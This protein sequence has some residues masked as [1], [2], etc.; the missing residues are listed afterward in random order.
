MNDQEDLRYYLSEYIDGDMNVNI[1]SNDVIYLIELSDSTN[2]VAADYQD[3]VLYVHRNEGAGLIGAGHLF[4]VLFYVTNSAA[5]G[6]KCT[7]VFMS[8]S[9]KDQN[10]SELGVDAADVG[11]FMVGAAF[12]LGDVNGD[13]VV[14]VDGDYLLAMQMAV[15]SVLPN[16]DQLKAGDIDGD[17]EITKTDATLIKRLAQG[18]PINPQSGGGGG[19]GGPAGQTNGYEISIGDYEVVIG[20]DI[21]VPLLLDN[22]EGVAD[23]QVRVN[24]DKEILS[25]LS[26]TNGT[27]TST[28]GVA[29]Q[30][31]A[32]YVDIVLSSDQALVGGNGE[33]AV[34]TFRVDW[35][36][37][38][39]SVSELTISE[40]GL[41][42]QYGEDLSWSSGL[43]SE[44]GVVWAVLSNGLDSDGDG[45]TDYQ[46]HTLDGRLS[47][48][49]W[50]LSN[51]YGTDTDVNDA[52]T[53]DDRMNDGDEKVAGTSALDDG[54]YLGIS[55]MVPDIGSSGLRV[56]W[57]SVDGIEYSVE[58][59]LDLSGSF[60]CIESNVAGTAPEN[61]YLDA[62]AID[63][64]VKYYRI[65]VE[66]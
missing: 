59:G 15:G 5:A 55:S 31:G 29:Y 54:S 64:V 3:V 9:L 36:A 13:A 4:D 12:M 49:P 46:E 20:E 18:L 33:I 26:V 30:A 16:A 66:E 1:G 60:T 53:D 58:R 8:V 51:P 45:L 35:S 32:G 63:G 61:E 37:E 23:I 6:S 38:A 56:K 21:Q 39:G 42:T 7:N 47:Y 17:G 41:G 50:G 44:G 2:G 48:D 43:S 28:F 52:D 25:V 11:V 10:G 62:G 34:I 19:D 24:Y 22:G 65:K 14:D 57:M 27:L 40:F